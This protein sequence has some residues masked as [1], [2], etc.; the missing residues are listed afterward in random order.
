MTPLAM[1]MPMAGRGSRFAK[2]G[3]DLPKPLIP[4]HGKPFFWW[5]T[6]SLRRQTP[7]REMVFVVL[8]E[9]CDAFGIDKTVLG[10]YPDARIVAIPEVTAGAA[11]TAMV[12]L[13]AIS[14]DG[15][16]AINDCDH[17]FACEG[18][19]AVVSRLG[20]ELG[21]ALMCFSS[22]NP[23]YSYAQL[24]EA[25]ERVARTA[26]KQVISPNAIGGCYFIGRPRSFEALYDDYVKSCPYQELFMSGIFNLMIERGENIA[27]VKAGLHRSFGTPDEMEQMDAQRFAPLLGWG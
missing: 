10:F 26:E 5:A 24:D 25:G 2:L 3:F 16:V 13:R 18:L 22:D 11:E 15:P 8:Q 6:E 19:D 21:G 1:V 12:G 9:H 17:A 7:L 20:G 23:A 14:Q 27:M 4:L